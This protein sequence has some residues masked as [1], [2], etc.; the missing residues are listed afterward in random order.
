MISKKHFT[1]QNVINLEQSEVL[2]TK[3]YSN[4]A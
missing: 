3:C 4:E 1:Q 2:D